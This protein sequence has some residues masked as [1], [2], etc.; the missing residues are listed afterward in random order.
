MIYI[1]KKNIIEMYKKGYSIKFICDEYYK[2]IN[3]DCEKA[4][5]Y[6]NVL[7]VPKQKINRKN[8]N[9]NVYE[10]IVYYNSLVN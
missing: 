6:N 3:K 2:S 1:N 8:C 9:K 4:H 7:V 10:T 5:W